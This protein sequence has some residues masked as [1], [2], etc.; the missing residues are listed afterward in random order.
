MP[1]KTSLALL[2]AGLPALTAAEPKKPK[3]DPQG[4]VLVPF[5]L[6]PSGVS[7]P[8]RPFTGALAQTV[9]ARLLP[10]AAAPAPASQAPVTGPWL[11]ATVLR[12][13]GH[14]ADEA[15]ALDRVAAHVGCE[16]SDLK[17]PLTTGQADRLIRHL[18]SMPGPD[19]ETLLAAS[20]RLASA[21]QG[22]P[23]FSFEQAQVPPT[24]RPGLGSTLALNRTKVRDG[25]QSLAWRFEPGA[26]LVVEGPVG[27]RPY[28]PN[29][30]DQARDAFAVCVYN[31]KPLEEPLR[32]GFSRKGGPEDCGFDFHL[33]F[34]GWR[35][36]WVLFERDMEGKPV[37]G[38][39]TLTFTA[40]RE[41]GEL[42]IDQLTPATPMDPRHP[43]RDDQVPKVNLRA[44]EAA[45]SHWQALMRFRAQRLAPPATLRV[46]EAAKA[47]L[48]ILE[49]RFASVMQEKRA[50]PEKLGALQTEFRALRL[51]KRDGLLTGR[52][53]DNR[54]RA[55]I[56][57]ASVRARLLRLDDHVDLQD[58]TTLIHRIACAWQV[59]P[60]P[61]AK[62]E[63]GVMYALM[64]EHALDQGWADGSAQGSVHHLGY[65]IRG[66]YASAFLMRDVLREAGLL[67]RLQKALYWYAGTGRIFGQEAAPGNID[68]FNTTLHGMVASLLLM[69]DGP[70]K[71]F[72]LRAFADWLSRGLRP[73]P[74]LAAAFKVDGAAYHHDNHYP[75]YANDGFAG[76]APIAYALGG[77]RTFRIAP[78]AHATMKQALLAMRFYA[79]K[80]QWLLAISGRHP[81]GLQGLR[82]P[83]F[84]FLALAGTPDGSKPVDPEMAAAFLRL[85]PEGD[86]EAAALR[87][88]GFQPEPDP[89]GHWTMNYGCIALHRRDQWLVGVKG[90]SRYLWGNESYVANNLYGRY[91]S[92]GHVQVLGG[93]SPVTNLASGFSHDG[94]DWNRWPGTTTIHLPL[95]QLKADVRNV[96]TFSGFEEMLIS[97]ETYAG[98]VS[99]GGNG[100]FALKLHEH[101]KYD[102]SHRARKSVF[103]VD[104]RLVL[105]GTGIQNTSTHPTETTLFQVHLPDRATPISLS[106]QGAVA[107]FPFLTELQTGA[108][109][110]LL[111]IQA[112]GYFVPA[113]Q[114]LLVQRAAQASL[115]QDTSRPTQ[116]AFA[117]ALLRHGVAPK[118][119]TYEYAMVV[120]TDPKAMEAF[121]AAPPYTVLR[122]D[123]RIHAVRDHAT[124]LTGI[125]AF[126]PEA[127]LGIGGVAAVDRPVMMLVKAEGKGLRFAITDPDLR[128]YEGQEADQVDAK[129][130]QREVSL[131]SRTWQDSPS[132]PAVTRV[133]FQGRLKLA[134]P[135]PRVKI[136]RA[137]A[138]ETVVVFTLKDAQP[139]E[140]TLVKP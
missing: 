106:G 6:L 124:G 134:Q 61:A 114:Q 101:G 21:A 19:G 131:Y 111:D 135:D 100:L 2:L 108:G 7:D 115:S 132:Q 78:D 14:T 29:P 13:Q 46:D 71:V 79:N 12:A 122:K 30:K 44:D 116:G 103:L 9:L 130:G 43:T 118:G 81:T 133:T 48:R 90:F 123:D 84:R 128:L 91:L 8:H 28:T 45:N 63:L 85:A 136:E 4:A 22:R 74:G 15:T 65:P 96:D 52:T 117:T 102:G 36:C 64:T 73:A 53:V 112:T 72:H 121:S 105:L 66:W 62:R 41:A 37:Q 86:P 67:P 49:T 27:F 16:L 42:L 75:A 20:I 35:T 31:A 82:I 34:T 83:P 24:F 33:D 140:I 99:M 92:Y 138:T 104:N 110:W 3:A 87:A 58:Y 120:R 97:D 69:D 88:Q 23:V 70:D 94:W 17:G 119:A 77:T 18:L 25:A 109:A 10:G 32:I 95:E 127:T 60:D 80:T 68:I 107:A 139:C 51:Q 39:D 1:W 5:G 11:A 98:G 59:S 38:M 54:Y 93:G 40:P 89:T 76:L 55:D 26:H 57:P 50:T 125:A 137:S 129:G 47:D 113:G 126:E 56:Y